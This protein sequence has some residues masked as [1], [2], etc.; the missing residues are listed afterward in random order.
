MR[1]EPEN[2]VDAWVRS[3]HGVSLY[4]STVS[5]A[6]LRYG[7]AILPEGRRRETYHPHRD[8]SF[9]LL[10]PRRLVP[11]LGRRVPNQRARRRPSPFNRHPTRAARWRA[12]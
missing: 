11:V 2:T 7:A 3:Q 10:T 8:L 1:S 12:V 4:F 6:K 5:E 9:S